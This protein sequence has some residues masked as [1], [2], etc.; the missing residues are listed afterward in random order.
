[1]NTLPSEL[2]FNICKFLGNNSLLNFSSISNK[3]RFI[4]GELYI[5]NNNI[6]I[7][8]NTIINNNVNNYIFNND[9]TYNQFIRKY[10]YKLKN[11]IINHHF[12]DYTKLEYLMNIKNLSVKCKTYTKSIKGRNIRFDHNNLYYDTLTIN[13]NYKNN[14][15]KLIDMRMCAKKLIINTNTTFVSGIV[16]SNQSLKFI[17]SVVL[18]E[19]N[20]FLSEIRPIIDKNNKIIRVDTIKCDYTIYYSILD[21]KHG[22]ICY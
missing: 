20:T 22:F 7:G 12:V 4:F 9:K 19:Y 14:R 5:P 17:K 15:Y 16:F 18:F 3:Y 6:F 13:V 8:N 21:Q 10:R 1:M 11:I 2:I